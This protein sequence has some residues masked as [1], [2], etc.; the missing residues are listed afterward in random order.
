MTAHYRTKAEQTAEAAAAAAKADRE[1]TKAAALKS[2]AAVRLVSP[3]AFY[4]DAGALH[5][6]TEG[7]IVAD[8]DEI[9]ILTARGAPIEKIAKPPIEKVSNP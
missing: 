6:W 4:D 8:P 5:S 3:F 1:A 9:G 2:G 7:A